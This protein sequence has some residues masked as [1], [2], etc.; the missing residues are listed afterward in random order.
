VELHLKTTPS[1]LK[2]LHRASTIKLVQHQQMVIKQPKENHAELLSNY[3][4]LEIG[5]EINSRQSYSSKPHTPPPSGGSRKFFQ[6][7]QRSL[8]NLNITSL[9]KK[10]T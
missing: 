6:G 1:E 5:I 7:V 4:H 2:F 3:P 8:Q 10:I 9:K